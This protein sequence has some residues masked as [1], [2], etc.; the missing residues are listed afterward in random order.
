MQEY[1]GRDGTW[2]T[3]HSLGEYQGAQEKK[4]IL[5]G[6]KGKASEGREEERNRKEE[7]DVEC[8]LAVEPAAKRSH[9]PTRTLVFTGPHH[10][11]IIATN[12]V[13]TRHDRQSDELG[14]DWVITNQ[15]HGRCRSRR[16]RN[17]D[18]GAA[19]ACV[20]VCTHA[21][22]RVCGGEWGQ[23]PRLSQLHPHGSRDSRPG[24]TPRAVL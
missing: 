2:G 6:C 11:C 13:S 22:V 17:A 5:D 3:S 20:V 7:S 10:P 8:Q 21:R 19:R 14:S 9:S 15:S 23:R 12:I 16:R 4:N 18:E 1:V 24:P